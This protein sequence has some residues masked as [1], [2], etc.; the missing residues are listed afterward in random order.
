MGRGQSEYVSHDCTE[1]TVGFDFL[2]EKNHPQRGH[3]VLRFSPTTDRAGETFQVEIQYQPL[4]NPQHYN[5]SMNVTEKCFVNIT[6]RRCCYEQSYPR[7][8]DTQTL[9]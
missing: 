8:L 3:P 9:R 6:Y 4:E 1:A 5:F 7:V 2:D